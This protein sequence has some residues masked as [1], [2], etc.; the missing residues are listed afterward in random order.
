MTSETEKRE[1]Y[2]LEAPWDKT[3]VAED[4]F[5]ALGETVQWLELIDEIAAS[6]HVTAEE[7]WDG[8][9]AAIRGYL[10]ELQ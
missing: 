3:R 9:A 2:E 7:A 8:M 4:K 10:E 6:T 1:W 5:L